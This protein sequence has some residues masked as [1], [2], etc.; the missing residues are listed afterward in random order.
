MSDAMVFASAVSTATTVESAVSEL[1]S[2]VSLDLEGRPVDLALVFYSPHH[3]AATR[4][5]SGLLRETIEPRLL[6]GA[7]GNGVIGRGREVEGGPAVTLLAGHLPDVSLLPVHLHPA[8]W[9]KLLDDDDAFAGQF[10]TCDKPRLILLLAD[11]FSTPID[12]LLESFNALFPGVPMIGGLASGAG[13]PHAKSLLLGDQVLAGGA[14]A[15]AFEGPLEVDVVVSQGCR[16]VG[17]PFT[18]TQSRDNVIV[19]LE[20]KPPLV[21]IQDLISGLSMEDRAILENG[22]FVGRA[23][24]PL[25]DQL[26]RGSFLIRG[27]TGADQRSGAIAIGDL[28]EPG[29]TIQ[30]HLRDAETAREDLEMMLSPQ[31]LF[32]MPRGGLLFSCN[33]RGTHLYDH[34]DGDIGTL[35]KVVG[36]IHLAGLFCAG[37]VGP[38][39]AQN[40][41]HG[42]T[43]SMV[44]FRPGKGSEKQ[45]SQSASE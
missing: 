33:G 15:V 27:V 20:G 34:P 29:E 1:F 36:D 41:L 31:A 3:E 35:H 14:L 32:N 10:V 28:I 7:M 2:Q 12:P 44:F 26:G 11:P 16:P 22:L 40:Y 21:R 24:S 17:E 13:R 8:D 30:F 45:A 39:G 5:L 43:A 19:S 38:V 42:H 37:E 9:E 23:V 18:V 4:R 25:R 6:V